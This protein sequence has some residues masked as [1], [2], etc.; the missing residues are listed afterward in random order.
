MI[1]TIFI[2]KEIY[3]LNKLSTNNNPNNSNNNNNINY[4]NNNINKIATK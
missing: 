3:N 4:N 2:L 1:P